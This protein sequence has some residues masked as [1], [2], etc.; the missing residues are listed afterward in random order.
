MRIPFPGFLA[1][2]KGAA[3]FALD[4]RIN[5]FSKFSFNHLRIHINSIGNINLVL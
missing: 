4:C 2:K 5:L 1:N 3:H